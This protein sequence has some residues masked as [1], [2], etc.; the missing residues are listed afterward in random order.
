M[1]T[2]TD[3]QAELSAVV[4]HVANLNDL[5]V[6]N[7]MTHGEKGQMRAAETCNLQETLFILS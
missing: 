3:A 6:A 4:E 7:A 1:Q 5:R 2:F